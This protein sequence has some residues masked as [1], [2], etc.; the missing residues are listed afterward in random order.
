MQTAS[1]LLVSVAFLLGLQVIAASARAQNEDYKALTDAAVEEHSLGHYQEARALFERAHAISPNARTLWGMGIAAFES[2]EYVDAIRLLQQALDDQRKPLTPPQRKKATSL[3]E[4]SQ[5]YVVRLPL[6]VQPATA[7]VSI[8]GR[9][10]QSD[11]DGIVL[12]DA[13][14]HQ[15]VVSADGYEDVVRSMVW[16]AGTAPPLE[17][18]LERK[19]AP[20]AEPRATPALATKVSETAAPGR[21]ETDGPRAFTVL[22][23]TSLGAAIASLGLVGAGV[24]LRE[25]EARYYNDDTH[26]PG[27][28]KDVSCPSSRD[29]VRKWEAVAIAGGAAATAF[30]AL[31][32]VFFVLDKRSAERAS[33]AL[34]CGP[35]FQVGATCRYR[36]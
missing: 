32:I 23:W 14:K 25:S 11:I 4:R 8:D 24:G 12:L 20:K 34:S 1:V 5:A 6:R 13:G 36:F 17:I 22:K 27:P 31:T 29:K 3:I 2:R 18:A 19:G 10:V 30:S 26:C 33:Q 7:A 21:S 35:A 28:D 15:L 16:H 9:A